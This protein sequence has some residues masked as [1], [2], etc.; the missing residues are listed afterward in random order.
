MRIRNRQISD[1]DGVYR[2]WA[3]APGIGLSAVND[4][5]E[6]I[7]KYLRRNPRTCFVAEKDGEIVGVIPDSVYTRATV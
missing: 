6:G 1:Y 7:E 3:D 2:L 5:R 4:S